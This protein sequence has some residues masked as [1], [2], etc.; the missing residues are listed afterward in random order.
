V[1]LLSPEKNEEN[2]KSIETSG[3][4]ISKVTRINLGGNRAVEVE[5]R[6]DGKARVLLCIG[7]ESIGID[8]VVKGEEYHLWATDTSGGYSAGTFHIWRDGT[9]FTCIDISEEGVKRGL[10]NENV[11]VLVWKCIP[12]F[13]KYRQAILRE[14][15]RLGIG[16]LIV[17]ITIT[18]VSL[19]KLKKHE[20]LRGICMNTGVS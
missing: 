14:E 2:K 10:F 1:L 13:Q 19:A 4:K 11:N 3:N 18:V 5:I 12:E 7:S 20:N 9:T 17:Y 6:E 15:E 16:L 8:E